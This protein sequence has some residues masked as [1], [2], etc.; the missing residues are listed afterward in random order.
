MY[1]SISFVV[2]TIIFYSQWK[3]SVLEQEK[4][5]HETLRL[6]FESLRNHVN[7]HF[8]FNSLTTLTQL[9]SIDP[10]KAIDFTSSMSDIFRN[11]LENKDK[12]LVLVSEEMSLVDSYL[13][14]QSIRFGN[15]VDVQNRITD[16]DLWMVIPVSIQMLIENVFKHNI[17]SKDN[18]ITIELW[19]ENGYLY[20]RNNLIEKRKKTDR[21]PTGLANI[22]NRY[23][24]LAK[25]PCLLEKTAEYFTI[26]LPLIQQST[27]I[28]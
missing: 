12:D 19:V 23:E 15:N 2:H 25:K 13:H 1:A 6:Q 8:L 27:L 5:K 26:G 16:A 11:I 28:Q 4:Q 9:I 24:F 7:P 10:E 20:V 18:H 17:I 14:L 21:T 3:N 22:R